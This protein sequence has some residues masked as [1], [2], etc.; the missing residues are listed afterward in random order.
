[1]SLN[2]KNP[3]ASHSVILY[4]TDTDYESMGGKAASLAQ[5]AAQGFSVPN[6]FVITPQGFVDSLSK[7]QQEQFE[8][9]VYEWTPETMPKINESLKTELQQALQCFS[10]GDLLAVRSS[11]CSEDGGVNSFAGQYESILNVSLNEVPEAVIKVWESG[12]SQRVKLYREQGGPGAK[13]EVPAVIVQRMVRADSAGVAFGADPITGD[14]KTAVVSAVYGLGSAL[15]GGDV[16][17]D[18]YHVGPL[19]QIVHDVVRKETMHPADGKEGVLVPVPEYLRDMPVLEDAQIRTVAQWVRKITRLQGKCQDIEWAFEK[20]R[21]F[22]LQSRPVTTLGA[23]VFTKGQLN[24]WDNSNIA[25]S[26]GGVTTPLTFSF[27]RKAYEEVYRQMCRIFKVPDKKLEVN[28]LTFERMLGLIN[29]RVYYNLLSWYKVLAMLP[30]YTFNRGFMEQ[31][32]GVK[33]GIPEELMDRKPEEGLRAKGWDFLMLV[34]SL[35]GLITSG[36]TLKSR[37]R[38]FYERLNGALKDKTLS[39][40][41]LD[42]LA[43]HYRCLEQQLLTRWDAPLVNDFFAMIYYGLLRRFSEKWCGDKAGT[44]HNDL[45]CGSGDIISAEPAKRIK[46]MG[47][48]IRENHLLVD[49]LRQGSRM[50]IRRSLETQPELSERVQA[51]IEKFGDRCLDELKLESETLHENPMPLYRSIGAFAT[52]MQVSE[53]G[54][55]RDEEILRNTAEKRAKEALRNHPVKKALFFWVAGNARTLVSNRENLRFERTRL[56]GHVRQLFLEIGLQ[57]TSFGVLEEQ[58]DIFYLEVHEIL[59]MVDGTCTTWNLKGLVALRKAEYQN[60]LST[61]APDDRFE[62][63]GPVGMGHVFRSTDKKAPLPE[64]DFMQ[65]LGCCPGRVSGPVRIVKDPRG[66]QMNP[67]EILVAERTDPGWIMLFPAAAGIL[68][69]RGSLLSHAAIVSREMGIPSVVS[70][71]G[72]TSWLNDGDL[73]TF[74]GTTGRVVLEKK[75][76]KT[77]GDGTAYAQ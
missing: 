61:D 39:A 51:Y 37:R 10:Q 40:M 57:L 3:R 2:Q 21:L 58:K 38:Q 7:F 27:I 59:G 35:L 11:A 32:M 19:D 17:G 29:G 67:G 8:D 44:L 49:T 52:L 1:M 24:L 23:S 60:R 9:G 66:I 76:E 16:Q 53:N 28:R 42:E 43:A 6:W 50:Q 33:Q 46:Q 26:Y 75:N 18:T 64:G 20:G 41:N 48:L 71:S 74:D 54:P 72:I 55:E 68:V 63:K 62:T 22:L 34:R 4:E 69:E 56:F 77:E 25:E 47:L 65:G 73:V 5:L 14:F 45:L 36:L 31:M 15:V 13:L 12:F 30:G 70:L